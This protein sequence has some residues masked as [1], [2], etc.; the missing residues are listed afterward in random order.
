MCLLKVVKQEIVTGLDDSS[1]QLS[2]Q[3]AVLLLELE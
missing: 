2:L 1:F 3:P